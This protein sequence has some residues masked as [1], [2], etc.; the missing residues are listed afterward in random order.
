MKI[1]CSFAANRNAATFSNEAPRY[2]PAMLR[3]AIA[4]APLTGITC[5]TFRAR[6]TFQLCRRI[7]FGGSLKFLCPRCPVEDAKTDCSKASGMDAIR[8]VLF[9]NR[10]SDAPV[11]E[12]ATF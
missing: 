7:N 9:G 12:T 6:T 11:V 10:W 8:S 2:N 3:Y 5:T 4:T 1:S